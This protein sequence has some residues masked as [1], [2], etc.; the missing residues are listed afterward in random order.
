[1]RTLHIGDPPNFDRLARPYRWLEYLTF[2]PYL[3]RCRFSRLAWLTDC[4]HALVYGDGDGRFLARLL[5][6]NPHISVDSVDCSAAMTSLVERRVDRIGS[7]ARRR[8]TLHHDNA[9]SFSSFS[10]RYDLLVAHFFL[11]CFSTAELN[12]LFDH[13]VPQLTTGALFLISEFA[14]I[15]GGPMAAVSRA[16]IA[17][18]YRVFGLLTK[19]GPRHLPDHSSVLSAHGFTLL[20]HKTWLGGLLVSELWQ[21]RN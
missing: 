20:E 12:V 13:T 1:M 19:L 17:V 5:R 18:L 10:F 16:I 11:D 21:L 6:S 8:L 7:S 4:R 9:L 15:E 2:G 3:E 14:T